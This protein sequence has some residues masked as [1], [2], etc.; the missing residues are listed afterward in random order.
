[1]KFEE[2]YCFIT[3]GDGHHFFIPV[4]KRNEFYDLCE[5]I[6]SADYDAMREVEESFAKYRSLAP[7]NY[8]FTERTILK[9]TD[10]GEQQC[11]QCQQC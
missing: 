8:M 9:E 3:D 5:R 1:M 4:T 7:C 11:Q 2:N 10:D 6:E